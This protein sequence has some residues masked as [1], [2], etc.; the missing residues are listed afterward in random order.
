MSGQKD[1]IGGTIV[2]IGPFYNRSGFGIGA[3]TIVSHLHRFGNRVRIVPVDQVEPGIDDC[4]LELIRSL[5]RTPLDPPITAIISHVPSMHW[6]RI[7]L[8]EP[9]L[10]IMATTAFDCATPD[11]PVPQEMLQVCRQMDQIWL[12][13]P[14]EREL[15]LREG[16]PSEQVHTL[17]WP[18]HWLENPFVPPAFPEPERNER[19]FRFLNISVFLPR[20]RW[21]TLIEA[22]LEEFNKTPGVELYLKVSYPQWHPVP[23]KPRRDFIDLVT[24][25]RRKTRSRAPIIIDEHLDTRLGVL[26]L[27][28]NCNAYISTDTAPTA[29]VSEATVRQRLVILPDGFIQWPENSALQIPV[30]PKAR[31]PITEEMLQYQPHHTGLWMPLL[32][33]QDVRRVM[34]QAYEMPLEERRA[35]AAAAAAA[36]QNPIELVR[37][38]VEA[39]RQGWKHK[40]QME[41]RK[42]VQ[43]DSPAIVWEGSQ[44]VRH[45]LALVNR[46]ICLRLIDEGYNVTILPFEPDE[47]DPAS[48]SRF[49][50]IVERTSRTLPEKVD[51]HVRHRWP[52]D[53]TPPANGR[54]VMIQ[55]WEFGS[56]PKAW[57]DPINNLVDEVWVPSSYVRECYVKSGV[58]PERVMVVPNGVDTSRFH[59]HAP[60]LP[61]DTQKRFKF[62]FVGGTIPRKGID[63][64][65]KAYVAAFTSEDD[66]CLVIKDMLTNSF[67]KEQTAR[68]MIEAIRST[69][70]S[71]EIVYIDE[72]LDER[73]M[74]SLYTACHCLVH[75]YRGEG[76]ALPVAEAMASGRP[77]VVTGYGAALDFCS[78]E[79]AYLLPFQ[80]RKL[81]KKRVQM[82]RLPDNRIEE[83]ETVDYPWLAEPDLEALKKIM[84]HVYENPEEAEKKGLA[85]RVHI[86]RHFTWEKTV[87]VVKKRLHALAENPIRRFQDSHPAPLKPQSSGA[88]SQTFYPDAQ[89]LLDSRRPQDPAHP[90]KLKSPTL[91]IDRQEKDRSALSNRKSRHLARILVEEGERRFQGGNQDDA[92]LCFEMALKHHPDCA[93]AH[94]NLGVLFWQLGDLGKALESLYRAFDLNPEDTDILL[95]SARVLAE[96]GET[97]TAADILRL[98]LRKSPDDEEAWNTYD[99]LV[100]AQCLPAWDP[101]GLPASVADIYLRMGKEL[102]SATDLVGA[103]EALEKALKLDPSRTDIVDELNRLSLPQ[104]TPSDDPLVDSAHESSK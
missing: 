55:P 3:R 27:I 88:S 7:K 40:R 37:K 8:P 76:F 101:E 95:N 34:R 45:S 79:N 2:W 94:N 64:L 100:R 19:P 84:R 46:E 15:F 17:L 14:G 12:H 104:T 73:D 32:H 43:R 53:F 42:L 23:G 21:D 62:L 22:F 16:F 39:I 89:T 49:T 54:W 61:L 48:D 102:A 58:T 91:A 81:F 47:M 31:K 67:Y 5:E 10:R 9:N 38:M 35:R 33:V 18:H 44:L 60:P 82:L 68:K 96:A 24:S 86:E 66:V 72:M 36:I 70:G 103:A 41:I 75:P 13:T 63:T 85:G 50:K 83:M 59:P 80:V 65:L 78:E 20:R 87:E 57:I 74:P 52:P 29:P 69:P 98:Y 71:P 77:V 92:R 99:Q 28:D 26:R 51:I 97:A 93:T 1:T 25:L 4:D 6:L 30:D 11:G 90:P 56:L